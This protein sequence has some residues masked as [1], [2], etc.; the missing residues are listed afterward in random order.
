MFITALVENTSNC[1][2]KTAHGLSLYIQTK[3]HQILFDLGPDHTLF[4]NAAKRGIDLSEIDTVII[5]HGHADHGGALCEFLTVNPT[6]NIYIQKRAFEPHLNKTFGRDKF[7][8]LD[9]SLVDDPQIILVDGDY[10]IDEELFLFTV[11]QTDKCHSPANDVLYGPSGRDDF[12]HEQNLL[13]TENT[14]A[15]VMGCGHCGIINI[16]DKAKSFQPEVCIGGFHLF[17]PTS[18]ESAPTSLLDEILQEL[19]TYQ[20]TRFYTCHCTGKEAY[21]YLSARQKTISYLSCG[22]SI[23]I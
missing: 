8:G 6:A 17:N 20:E 19:Q 18:K 23:T 13:I 2:L 4:A 15:L 12:S 14:T 5:S 10:K 16:L 7:I 21:D 22:E 3:N 11:T 9:Q 1:E